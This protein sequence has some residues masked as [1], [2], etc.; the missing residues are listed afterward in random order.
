MQTISS[1]A[2]MKRAAA[3]A[4]A[5]G[6]RI[7]FVPTMGFLHEGHAH[8]L[9]EARR[10]GDL[11]V[12]SVFVNPLQFGPNEDFAQYPRDAERDRRVAAD[13]GADI[14]WSPRSEEMYPD[15]PVVTVDPGPAGT[16]LEGAIRPGHF[17][18]VLT[19]V[20]KL[21]GIVRPDV[22]V[23][24][25]KDAQQAFLVRRMVHDLNIPVA[26]V[27]GPT[28]RERDGLAMSSR[29]V[30]LDPAMRESAAVLP[31][32]LEAGVAAFRAGERKAGSVVAATYRALASAEGVT[33]EYI[34]VVEPDAFQPNHAATA[35]SYL[36]V[37][38]RVGPKRLIDNVVLGEGLEGDPR[39]PAATRDPAVVG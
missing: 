26:I 6:R 14:L 27:V 36:V 38:A 22:A 30:Y 15:E 17:A 28:V 7:A 21:F 1:I 3:D 39:S 4:R 8:L 34:N 32:A 5:A 24:G 2:D 9:R 16:I 37:A 13:A 25:R 29:N 23:F 11:V 19:V 12:L 35:R 10:H 31:R 18:G 20:L 33:V